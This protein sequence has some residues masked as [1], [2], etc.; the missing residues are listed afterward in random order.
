MTNEIIEINVNPVHALTERLNQIQ[1]VIRDVFKKDLDYGTIP[2]TKKPTLYKP[3]AEKLCQ[4]FGLVADYEVE[5]KSQSG[6]AVRYVECGNVPS[7]NVPIV[8]YL[9]KCKIFSMNGIMLGSGL[10]EA[11]S[12]ETR[13]A[14]K[15]CYSDDEWEYYSAENRKIKFTKY[16]QERVIRENPADKANSILKVAKKRSFVDA[17][18]SV[19]GASEVFTQDL[20]DGVPDNYINDQKNGTGMEGE[21]ISYAKATGKP[22]EKQIKY[23]KSLM[24]KN[25]LDESTLKKR[26]KKDTVEALGIKQ[27]DDLIKYCKKLET[28][29]TVSD[30]TEADPFT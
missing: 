24:E 6:P 29:E 9:V 10:G 17:V 13:N 26:Y 18:L 20:E 7:S 27:V 19:V 23:A 28:P 22:L 25:G 3:G 1:R 12:E 21:P 4:V 5:D 30:E 14:W 8:R 15:K 11:S 2:G 16:G